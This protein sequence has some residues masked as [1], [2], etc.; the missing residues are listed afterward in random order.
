MHLWWV[1]FMS[2]QSKWCLL[3]EVGSRFMSIVQ[4]LLMGKSVYALFNRSRRI[5]FLV[6][7]HI[8]LQVTSSMVNVIYTI[9]AAKYHEYCIFSKPPL[10]LTYHG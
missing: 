4:V 10:Q 9:R 7:F 2:Q 6:G 8:L 3:S 5:A 1:R